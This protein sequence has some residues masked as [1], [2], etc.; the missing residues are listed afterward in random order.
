MAFY[1]FNGTN[2]Q[3]NT[4]TLLSIENDIQMVCYAELGEIMYG[5]HSLH[6]CI[7]NPRVSK[8]QPRAFSLLVEVYFFNGTNDQQK[9]ATLL[10]IEN[11]IR[12]VCYAELGEIMYVY[13]SLHS[14]LRVC[15]YFVMG[16]PVLGRYT[17]NWSLQ[18]Q[19]NA[20]LMWHPVTLSPFLSLTLEQTCT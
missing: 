17:D 10:S 8:F 6:Y 20:T 16:R 19:L 12:M 13:H 14:T 15:L 4:A 2:N 7:G 11:D 18:S 1:S 5:Y 9:T 3:T